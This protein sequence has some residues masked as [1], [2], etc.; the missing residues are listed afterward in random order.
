LLALKGFDSRT[1]DSVIVVV[2]Q[3]S[4]YVRYLPYRKDIDA[5]ALAQLFINRIVLN[6]PRGTLESLIIDRGAMFTSVY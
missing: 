1:Y 6:G 2:N 4:K 5:L 3:F